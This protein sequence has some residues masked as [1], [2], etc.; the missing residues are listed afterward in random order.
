ML[1]YQHSYHAGNFADV[2]KHATLCLVLRHLAGQDGPMACFDAFA[3]RG[4]YNLTGMEAMKTAEYRDGIGKL[5]EHSAPPDAV[6]P[7]LNIVREA[8]AGEGE[9]RRYPGSPALMRRFL[10]PGDR[11]ILLERHPAEHAALKSNYGR[12]RQIQ[13]YAEDSHAALPSLLPPW[14]GRGLVLLDPSYEVK[15]EYRRMAELLHKMHKKWPQGVFM[16][17]YPILPTGLHVEMISS[18]EAKKLPNIFSSIFMQPG[19][20]MGMTGSGL[21]FV[22]LPETLKKDVTLVADAMPL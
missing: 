8:N 12:D 9:L 4:T 15:D 7:Y 1:S 6:Q 22:N 11:L 21:F 2:H 20:Q 14:E 18:L 13:V 10:R 16:L 17:W 3:G 19:K 5:Y